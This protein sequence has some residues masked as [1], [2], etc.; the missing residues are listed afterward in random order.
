MDIEEP[1]ILIFF[2]FFDLAIGKK[3]L[4][5]SAIAQLFNEIGSAAPS[6]RHSCDC[7]KT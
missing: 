4:G 5:C 1:T 2:I 7:V 3:R 6:S